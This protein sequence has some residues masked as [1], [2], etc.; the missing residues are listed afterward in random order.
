MIYYSLQ[1]KTS[2]KAVLW[3]RNRVY[4]RRCKIWWG[5]SRGSSCDSKVKIYFYIFTYL[6]VLNALCEH[7]STKKL[8]DLES[9]IRGYARYSSYSAQP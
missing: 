7:S 6:F 2:K 9:S 3:Q 5:L 1:T 4:R 8:L